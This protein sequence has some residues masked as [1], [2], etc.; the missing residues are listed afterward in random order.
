M[1]WMV[2]FSNNGRSSHN[3][4]PW[5]P[6]GVWTEA[7]DWD[8][9]PVCGGGLHG[10]G[11]GGWGHA[12]AGTQFEFCE[13]DPDAGLVIVK[14][15]K[16]KCRRARIVAIDAEAWRQVLAHLPDGAFPG[17]LDLRDYPHPLPAGLTRIGGG[18]HVEGYPHPLPA[19]LTSIGGWLALRRY[20]H[21]LPAGLTSIGDWLDVGGYSHPLPAGLT[22]I[23]GW[24]DL[25]G[26]PHPLPAGLT[27]IGGWLTLLGYPHPLP[28]GLTVHGAIYR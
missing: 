1:T 9:R 6:V 10:Q 17:S 16:L 18:L 21:P 3:N 8:P 5:A 27:S 13:I 19:G 4:F 7:P 22:S 28:A 2:R 24:L 26:Y 15:D 23:G 11:P 14:D 12:Q 20:P 25:V